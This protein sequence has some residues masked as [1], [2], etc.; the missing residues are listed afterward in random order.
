MKEEQE[1]QEREGSEQQEQSAVAEARVATAEGRPKSEGRPRQNEG[2]SK[3]SES[4]SSHSPTLEGD[5]AP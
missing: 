2:L 3:I 4:P 5:M 1:R